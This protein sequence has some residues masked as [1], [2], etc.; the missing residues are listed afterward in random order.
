MAQLV[1]RLKNVP[2]EEVDDI[3]QLLTDNEIEFYETSAGRWQI[4]MAGIWIKD[5]TQAQQAKE[6]IA[7]DQQQR[8][9][10]AVPIS[11]WDWVSGALSHA[12]Q[13]PVEFV[14]TLIAIALVLGVS[15]LPFFL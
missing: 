4:S 14:F 11:A 5:K 8:A 10:S 3:R 7:Q 13:N 9:A 6:L 1:F 12:R 2:D 15:V